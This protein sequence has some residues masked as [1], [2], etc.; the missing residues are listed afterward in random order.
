MQIS[1]A[2]ETLPLIPLYNKVLLPSI[3]TD[4]VLSIDEAQGLLSLAKTSIYIVCVPYAPRLHQGT[5]EQNSNSTTRLSHYGCTAR[6]L[7]IDRPEPENITLK[8]EGAHRSRILDITT[9][10]SFCYAYLEHCL[11]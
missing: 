6:I 5:T 3:V 10:G 1:N 8:V 4:L 7:S 2:T 11:D 9:D